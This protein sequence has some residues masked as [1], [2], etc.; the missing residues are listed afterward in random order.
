MLQDRR[1]LPHHFGVSLV[2]PEI[3]L[4][5]LQ[6]RHYRGLL[7][8]SVHHLVVIPLYSGTLTATV[9]VTIEMFLPPILLRILLWPRISR[10]QLTQ[11]PMI[12]PPNPLTLP[13]LNLP[14]PR[15]QL[16]QV[17]QLTL[18]VLMLPTRK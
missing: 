9:K 3:F 10:I 4:H 15:I 14:P 11:Q 2:L 8:Q 17:S 16:L 13:I 18:L 5:L 1:Q 7:H 6:S 12:L